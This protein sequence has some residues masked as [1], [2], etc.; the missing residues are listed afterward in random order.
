MGCTSLTSIE[1]EE[2]NT[3]YSS[4]EGVL[5]DES[6]TTLIQYPVGKKKESYDI[7]DSVTFI[8]DSA[9]RGCT[10]L[11]SVTIPEKV[12]TIAGSAFMGC[13]SLTSVTFLGSV[14]DIEYE[15]FSGCTSLTSVTIPEK[16]TSI[17]DS[18]FY[19]CTSLTSVTIPE[20]VTYIGDEVFYECTSLTSIV[21]NGSNKNF[22]SD[23]GVLFNKSKT[24]LMQYP[25][26]K[27]D[28]SSY[29]IPSSVT[30]IDP[31]AL[32]GCI[33]LTSIEVEEGNTAY[34]SDGGVLFNKSKTI[35]MQYPAGKKNESYVIPDSVT[36]IADSTFRGCT[37]L[38]SV[39]IHGSVTT[40][41]A[42]VFYGCTSL[43]SIK[44]EEGN[45]V[46]SSEGG[47]L[48]NKSKT[49]LMQYPAGK[50]DSSYVIPDSVTYIK[51]YAFYGCTSLES[52]TIPGKD[53]HVSIN[54]FVDCTSLETIRITGG[55]FV[56]FDESSIK[57]TDGTEHT[58][59]VVAPEGFV[60]PG[61][62]VSGD[63]KIVYGEKPS[64]SDGFP[65][66][67]AA[68]GIVAA[69]ALIG[70]AVVLRRRRV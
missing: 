7:P 28:S 38:T 37:A 26:G 27:K 55:I 61:D 13:T 11:T 21:V 50:N 65:I 49:N 52:V 14:T 68:V 42:E 69:L 45:T 59:Y 15:A 44:V 20:K 54:A 35:L 12:T 70:G 60:I 56:I 2:G 47:V 41:G 19:G 3:A 46:Y 58:L 32:D 30:S 66:V 36:S 17:R 43:E 64:G 24:I 10:S 6:K 48:F 5:F 63:V 67:Y 39:T 4:E 22:S 25:A 16:V 33:F 29:T 8:I 62:A 53:I 51:E 1:V 57:F 9:F 18:A 23:G 31:C 40:I 34:S